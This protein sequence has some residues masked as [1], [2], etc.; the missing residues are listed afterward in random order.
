MNLTATLYERMEA[1]R[2][3]RR[4]T[5]RPLQ[6]GDLI[7]VDGRVVP[8]V[9]AGSAGECIEAE[10]ERQIRSLKCKREDGAK[11]V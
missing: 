7:E 3:E 6:R 11:H 2:Q 10:T 8:L 9:D 4:A 1:Q 5:G